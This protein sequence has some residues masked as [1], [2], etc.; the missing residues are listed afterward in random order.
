MFDYPTTE[1]LAAMGET[2]QRD[3]C[4]WSAQLTREYCNTYSAPLYT[5]S[6]PDPLAEADK[7]PRRKH[8]K[9]A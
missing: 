2:L 6:E 1:A 7:P 9:A 3:V 5:R 4:L 8:R